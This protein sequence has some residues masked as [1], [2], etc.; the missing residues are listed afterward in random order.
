MRLAFAKEHP[1]SRNVSC[2][3]AWTVTRAGTH[4]FDSTCKSGEE[5]WRRSYA[6]CQHDVNVYNDL[7]QHLTQPQ[8]RHT[9][10]RLPTTGHNHF[11]HRSCAKSKLRQ[12]A[13]CWVCHHVPQL[14]KYFT[15]YPLPVTMT[16]YATS[17]P[18]G[19]MPLG[20]LSDRS[21]P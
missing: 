2:G 1:P 19:P 3:P 4:C 10:S 14:G 17:S 11:S 9:A 18:N 6:L 5:I 20:D 16:C 7:T 21:Q 15:C 13:S 8:V 12:R